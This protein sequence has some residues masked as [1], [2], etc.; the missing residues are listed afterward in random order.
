MYSSYQNYF[1]K[2]AESIMEHYK[3]KSFFSKAEDEKCKVS[4]LETEKWKQELDA[5]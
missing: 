3:Q 4:E 2:S 5:T 1:R